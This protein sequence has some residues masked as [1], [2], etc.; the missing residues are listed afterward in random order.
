MAVSFINFALIFISN[1]NNE[2][3]E[4]IIKILKQKKGIKSMINGL[5]IIYYVILLLLVTS[6]LIDSSFNPFLYF[7][8]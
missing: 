5:E 3:R 2:K 4:N 6:F 8:F 7:R 1:K